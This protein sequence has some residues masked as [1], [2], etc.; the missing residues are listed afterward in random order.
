MTNLFSKDPYY[1]NYRRANTPASLTT[2]ET[3]GSGTSSRNPYLE[4]NNENGSNV[5][6]QNNNNCHGRNSDS[7]KSQ[8]RPLALP[9]SSSSSKKVTFALSLP[10]GFPTREGRKPL[11]D[12]NTDD[13]NEVDTATPASSFSFSLASKIYDNEKR[14]R[15]AW[16]DGLNNNNSNTTRSPPLLATSSSYSS[17]LLLCGEKDK[18]TTNESARFDESMDDRLDFTNTSAAA[19]TTTTAI[20]TAGRVTEEGMVHQ[21]TKDGTTV[22]PTNMWLKTDPESKL[23]F[24]LSANEATTHCSLILR[25]DKGTDEYIAFKVCVC[26]RDFSF[27]FLFLAK[28]YVMICCELETQ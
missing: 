23:V 19:T 7:N 14:K 3:S 9:R 5:F 4:P 16:N 26:V 1:R 15:T 27:L 11:T 13:D 2:G 10:S 12:I 28:F 24:T 8:K 6:L 21:T 22:D 18:T 25:H 20:A 17:S